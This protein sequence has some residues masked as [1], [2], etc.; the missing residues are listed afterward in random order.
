MILLA[1]I[2]TA[3]GL[4]TSCSE[5]FVQMFPRSMGYNWWAVLFSAASF[6]IANVGLNAIIQYSLPVLMMLYPLAM[7]LILASLAE[8]K[9]RLD[10]NSYRIITAVTLACAL[11]DFIA[12]L[13]AQ[14]RAFLRLDPVQALYARVLPLYGLGLG[15]LL[16]AAA[17]FF[18]A[19]LVQKRAK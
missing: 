7:T 19:L 1:C 10:R 17:A 4:I 15:W 18:L 16:P 12:A 6:A 13:P 2:K 9:L 5:A 14:V 11:G 3:I 8:R